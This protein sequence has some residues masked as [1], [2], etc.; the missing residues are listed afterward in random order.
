M[1]LVAIF[2]CLRFETSLF[3]ASNDSQGFYSLVGRVGLYRRDQ[4]TDRSKGKLFKIL[5]SIYQLFALIAHISQTLEEKIA[6]LY[7]L[8]TMCK[9]R[10]YTGMPISSS[11]QFMRAA[12]VRV[13]V[14]VTLRLAVYRQSV[15]LGDKP[16]ET[17]DQNFYFPTERLRLYPYVTSSLPKRMSLSFT[18][19]AGPCQ[20][21][22]SQVHFTVSDS[23]LPQPGGPGPRIYIP[24]EQGDPVIPPGTGFPFRCLLRLGGGGGIRHCLHT[25]LSADDSSYT[26]FDDFYI[27]T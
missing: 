27:V 24:Q 18:V 7:I 21:R 12:T 25:G 20:R 10:M 6:L 4:G 22:H 11:F 19:A 5:L 1:A 16:L 26:D 17:H 3:V 2:Y 23:R 15:H 14:R 9:K 13:R 8:C